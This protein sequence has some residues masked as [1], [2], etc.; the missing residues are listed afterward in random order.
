MDDVIESCA[1][2][3]EEDGVNQQ[4]LDDLRKR[5]FEQTWQ[6]KLT[7]FKVGTFPW[8][9]PP[10][11][12]P[13]ANPTVPSNV[14]RPQQVPSNVRSS[15]PTPVPSNGP[16]GVRIKTEPG[17]EPQ[18]YQPPGMLQ[19]YSGIAKQRAAQ[20]LEQRFGTDA[21]SQINQ[22]QAQAAMGIPGNVPQRNPMNI[23]LPPQMTDQQRQQQ[24]EYKRRQQV[25]A[26]QYQ[27]LQQQAQQKPPIKTAQNDG[28]GDWDTYV[29][30]RRSDAAQYSGEADLT[31]REQVEQMNRSME[32]GG[33]MMPLAEQPKPRLPKKRKISGGLGGS[34]NA[35]DVALTKVMPKVAQVDG[36]ADEDDDEDD[37][38]HVKDE[39]FGGDDGEDGQDDEDD[40]DA[41]NSDLDDP[42]DALPEEEQDEGRPNQIMLCTY[43]KVARVKNKWKCTLKDGVLTTGGKEYIFHRAQGEF[44]W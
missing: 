41:I 3:F 16:N 36:A 33:L 8:E 39:L 29:A 15:S 38:T 17:Y 6:T 30:Q 11:P 12:Q 44:E 27:N 25:Q 20:A 26:Q 14:P 10:A 42:D 43:D 18:T 37:K 40:E 24:A 31:I 35:S 28:A 19:D 4:T 34:T 22:L 21:R 7:A 5:C 2:T 9:P 1:T 23:Q 13:M 32:G